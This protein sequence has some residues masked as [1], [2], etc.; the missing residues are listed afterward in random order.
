MKTFDLR[1]SYGFAFAFSTFRGQELEMCANHL[2]YGEDNREMLCRA[3]G[4]CGALPCAIKKFDFHR[5]LERRGNFEKER[6]EI[7]WTNEEKRRFQRDMY[8]HYRREY[9]AGLTSKWEA[10]SLDR[11]EEGME[12]SRR[13]LLRR[14]DAVEG[15]VRRRGAAD[16]HEFSEVLA[17]QRELEAAE[18]RVVMKNLR[19]S[20][21]RRLEREKREEEGDGGSGSSGSGGGGSVSSRSGERSVL[22]ERSAVGGTVAVESGGDGESASGDVGVAGGAVTGD[23]GG[24]ERRGVRRRRSDDD[25][26]A[27]GE[28]D[29]GSGGDDNDESR[30]LDF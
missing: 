21:R 1:L 5:D 6:K 8:K 27:D 13:E 29:G 15:S 25:D 3:C 11:L 4:V 14:L 9:L 23:E 18:R 17:A 30:I 20:E 10:K 22:L 7:L 26:D 12:L 2:Y 24:Q 28:D 16:R 19:E